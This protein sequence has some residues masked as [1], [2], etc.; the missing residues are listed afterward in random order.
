MASRDSSS[1][2]S[3][4]RRSP[5]DDAHSGFCCIWYSQSRSNKACSAAVA[6]SS[7]ANTTAG[8]TRAT[9]RMT[10]SKCMDQP[11]ARKMNLPE[12]LDA[13]QGQRSRV[14][15]EKPKVMI[16]TFLFSADSQDMP[17]IALT[18]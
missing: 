4:H 8:N 3:F 15:R 6:L 18:E 9:T 10:R 11:P 1:H 5:K 2:L 13:L 17:T 7:A 16:D 12:P 14:S